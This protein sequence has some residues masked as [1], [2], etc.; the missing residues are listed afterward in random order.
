MYQPEQ[1]IH[2]LDR[3]ENERT[4]SS[5]IGEKTS[6]LGENLSGVTLG[7]VEK[8]LKRCGIDYRVHAQCTTMEGEMGAIMYALKACHE[9][10]HAM[11]CPR[12]E[13]NVR[14]G[15]GAENYRQ[16]PLEHA[17]DA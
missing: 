14:F 15:T 9:A 6:S 12:I 3:E 5:S 10:L 11:G 4:S 13:S 1:K 8:V 16:L 7:E 2:P 17:E